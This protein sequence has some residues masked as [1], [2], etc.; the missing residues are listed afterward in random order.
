M[1]LTLRKGGIMETLTNEQ[2]AL[3]WQRNPHR[4]HV[5]DFAL[6][7]LYR[8]NRGYFHKYALRVRDSR[9][10]YRD[11]FQHS[12]P[13]I[14]KALESFEPKQG[15]KFF[16]FA[17]WRVK[18]SLT[19]FNKQDEMIKPIKVKDEFVHCGIDSLHTENREGQTRMD[20][21]VSEEVESPED[22]KNY[23]RALLSFLTEKEYDII[24]RYFGIGFGVSKTLEQIGIEMG[25]TTEN[26]RQFK[27]GGLKKIR[28]QVKFENLI[29]TPIFKEMTSLYK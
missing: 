2:L 19:T 29:E 13:H 20:A 22:V 16:S 11:F 1:V 9:N 27:D 28:G 17:I 21:L 23:A 24:C 4:K 10:N 26:I 14:I 6:T 25:F 18:A 3:L 12:V 15:F 8:K 7:E 5:R